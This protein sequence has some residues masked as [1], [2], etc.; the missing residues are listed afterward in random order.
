M[1]SSGYWRSRKTD[2]EYDKE[3]YNEMKDKFV[4]PSTNG[5]HFVP[6]HDYSFSFMTC[7]KSLMIENNNAYLYRESF[8]FPK[9]ELVLSFYVWMHKNS[10]P[11]S[12]PVSYSKNTVR[13]YKGG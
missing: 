3:S 9:K 8:M 7:T 11:H 12:T 6:Y 1:Y 2:Q 5:L 4:G 13:V 10:Q